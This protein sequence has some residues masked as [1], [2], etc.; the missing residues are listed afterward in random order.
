MECIDGWMDILKFSEVQSRNDRF[1]LDAKR[2]LVKTALSSTHP[3]S[4]LIVCYLPM[5]CHSWLSVTHV[6]PAALLVSFVY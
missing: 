3:F 1:S 4:T 5:S 6:T 2:F